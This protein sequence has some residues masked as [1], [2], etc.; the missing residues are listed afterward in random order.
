[1]RW[2]PIVYF[3]VYDLSAEGIRGVACTRYLS[4]KLQGECELRLVSLS[5][6][7]PWSRVR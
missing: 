3:F 6:F 5:T 1:M 2:K 4:V 7:L